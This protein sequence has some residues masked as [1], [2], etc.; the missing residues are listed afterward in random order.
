MKIFP[1]W[2]YKGFQI[3]TATSQIMKNAC[4]FLRHPAA[5]LR[6]PRVLFYDMGKK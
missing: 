4:A 3:E 2:A 5:A 6:L 1:S